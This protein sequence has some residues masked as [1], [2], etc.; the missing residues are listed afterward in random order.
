MR[1]EKGLALTSFLLMLV[2]ITILSS[3]ALPK[4]ADV[5]KKAHSRAEMQTLVGMIQI[6]ESDHDRLPHDLHELRSYY[7]DRGFERDGHGNLYNYNKISRKICGTKVGCRR[8]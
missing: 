6:F 8:F 7:I 3:V 4:I 5:A 2:G 1:N